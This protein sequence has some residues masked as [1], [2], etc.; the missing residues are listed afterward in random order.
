MTARSPNDVP[1]PSLSSSRRL[2]LVYSSPPLFT[3][4]SHPTRVTCVPPFA[5]PTTLSPYLPTRLRRSSA[6]SV[7]APACT[8]P[9]SCPLLQQLQPAAR[10]CLPLQP[11]NLRHVAYC[12]PVSEKKESSSFTG[13]FNYEKLL[14]TSKHLAAISHQT[15]CDHDRKLFVALTELH[16]V[17]LP[18][19]TAATSH[20]QFCL[21]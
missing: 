4:A 16:F 8:S 19:Q 5:S 18:L 14:G 9:L 17:L 6:P 21:L 11:P 3:P 10:A 20:R 7:R 2:N 13:Y 1:G 15:R 12:A